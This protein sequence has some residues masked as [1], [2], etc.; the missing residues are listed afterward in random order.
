VVAKGD[1]GRRALRYL[2]G[3]AGAP[4]TMS[5]H[6]RGRWRQRWIGWP[7][8]CRCGSER[9]CHRLEGRARRAAGQ[10]GET[11][12]RLPAAARRSDKAGPG[13][14]R[15][16]PVGQRQAS[17]ACLRGVPESC[18]SR[19]QGLCHQRRE[20]GWRTWPWPGGRGHRPLGVAMRVGRGRARGG[21]ACGVRDGEGSLGVVQ[22][23][24]K[25]PRMGEGRRSP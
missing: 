22:D 14:R 3:R 15:A 24:R 13:R 17:R 11:R 16:A 9:R 18:A 12:R 7:G 5:V 2:K 1:R 19:G 21:R 4:C 23:I 8:R 20:V 10:G 25:L 6:R